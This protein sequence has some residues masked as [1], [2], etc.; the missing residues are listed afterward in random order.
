MSYSKNKYEVNKNRG[1]TT[2]ANNHEATRASE[3]SV[4]AQWDPKGHLRV[5][6]GKEVQ[7]SILEPLTWHLPLGSNRP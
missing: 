7:G 6:E 1:S 4:A 5:E 2:N 3:A